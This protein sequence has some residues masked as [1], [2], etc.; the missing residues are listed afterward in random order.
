MARLAGANAF[1]IVAGDT[2]DLVVTVRDQDGA[3][4]DIS[5]AT[6]IRWGM[7]DAPGGTPLFEKSLG[8]GIALTDDGTDGRF[9]VRLLGP[10]TED[11][12]PGRRWHEAEVA[13]G[14]DLVTVVQ[15]VV[16]V[17]AAMLRAE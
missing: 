15:D 3:I 8:A 10:D 7:A 4:V 2:R 11:L 12:A 13:L 16:M 17:R 9:T 14:D 6:A 1:E 5:A